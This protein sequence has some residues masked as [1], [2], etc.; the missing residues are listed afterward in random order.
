MAIFSTK[1]DMIALVSALLISVLAW[2]PAR[3]A[4]EAGE[5]SGSQPAQMTEYQRT[6]KAAL[7][8]FQQGNFPEARSLFTRAHALSPNARTYRGLGF[9]AFELRNY[10]ECVD[11]LTAALKSTEKALEGDLRRTTEDLLARAKGLIARIHIDAKPSPV[12]VFVDGVPARLFERSTLILEVGDHVVE[13]RAAGYLPERRALKI[14]GGEELQLS[15][16]MR[17]ADNEDGEQASVSSEPGTVSSRAHDTRVGRPW[18][19]SPWLW[20][21]V[22]VVVVGAGVGAA[23]ALTYDPNRSKAKPSTTDNTPPGGV[24]QTLGSW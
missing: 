21:A 12:D 13:L 7:D 18:Y 2:V 6:I 19:K 8:E 20:T 24:V 16:V 5:R 3:A 23:V 14:A 11:Y 10:H 1:L 22:A 17:T 9:V 15:V 4:P